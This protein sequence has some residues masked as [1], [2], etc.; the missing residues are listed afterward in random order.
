[1]WPFWFQNHFR[2]FKKSKKQTQKDPFKIQKSKTILKSKKVR[3]LTPPNVAILISKPFLEFQKVRKKTKKCHVSCVTCH[4]SQLLHVVKNVTLDPICYIF[5]ERW[6]KIQLNDYAKTSWHMSQSK[7]IK[8]EQ[9]KCHIWPWVY[10][11]STYLF[12]IWVFF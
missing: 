3:E 8:V 9:T 6:C 10:V 11:E 5:L 7:I 4:M 2:N 12:V 1:M